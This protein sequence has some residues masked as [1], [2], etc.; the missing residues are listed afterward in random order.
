M[1]EHENGYNALNITNKHRYIL[2]DM[3]KAMGSNH[4]ISIKRRGGVP[5]LSYFQ[6]QIRD[7][8][9]YNDL[10]DL[11]ITPRKSRTIRMPNVPAAFVG[12][13]MRGCFDG[14]GSITLWQDPRWRHPWQARAVFS[15]GNR[16]FLTDIQRKLNKEAGL[17]VGSIQKTREEYQLCYSIAD[18]I[19]LYRFMY[20]NADN[21][22]MYLKEKLNKFKFFKKLRPERFRDSF[23]N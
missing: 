7:R 16:D 17:S 19:K 3:L 13:F 20:K 22:F 8:V 14:D 4:K 6:I 11:G 9:I 5:N 23:K 21:G 12:D 2:Q 15:S 1:V 18:S 10:L